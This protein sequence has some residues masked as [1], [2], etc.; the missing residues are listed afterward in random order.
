MD[1][2]SEE[3][4]YKKTKVTKT[5]GGKGGKEG[6]GGKGGKGGKNGKPSKPKAKAKAEPKAFSKKSLSRLRMKGGKCIKW[7][8]TIC[9]ENPCKY[10][11][12]CAVCGDP[13]C[14][15]YWHNE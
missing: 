9:T 7:N 6:K 13:L 2:S 12:E 5:K 10:A 3:P 14:A 1:T 11:H 8:T 4:P 15:A